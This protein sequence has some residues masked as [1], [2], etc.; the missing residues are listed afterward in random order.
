MGA[1]HKNLG[2][3]WAELAPSERRKYSRKH[4]N[5]NRSV[6]SKK[7][8]KSPFIAFCK[9]RRDQILP[10]WRSCHYGLGTKWEMLSQMEKDAYKTR[11]IMLSIAHTQHISDYIE[12]T[13]EQLEEAL[14]QLESYAEKDIEKKYSRPSIKSN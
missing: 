2:K 10:E 8:A 1:L 6:I 4:K 9:D 11:A 7:T 5:E 14:Q 3:Q 12:D 13:V